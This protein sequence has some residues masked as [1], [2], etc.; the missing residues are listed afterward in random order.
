[1]S[2]PSSI[3]QDNGVEFVDYYFMNNRSIH[4]EEAKERDANYRAQ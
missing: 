1:M 3:T 4:T 2:A